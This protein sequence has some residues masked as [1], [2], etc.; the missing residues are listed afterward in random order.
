MN[1]GGVPNKKFCMHQVF[2]QLSKMQLRRIATACLVG[3][4]F[5]VSAA[6][7]QLSYLQP[8]IA[9]S[10]TPEARTSQV[11]ENTQESEGGFLDTV[12][13]KLN[14]DESLPQSTKTFIKQVQG[15]DVQAEEPRPSGKGESPQNN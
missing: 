6:V 15:E 13:E 14:L 5:F 11:Q 3:L 8:A 9:A 1:T 2:A 10:V 12:R 7:G 4:L